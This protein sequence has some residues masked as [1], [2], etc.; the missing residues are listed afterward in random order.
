MCHE[1]K[2]DSANKQKQCKKP[3]C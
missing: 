1:K 3:P 2:Q